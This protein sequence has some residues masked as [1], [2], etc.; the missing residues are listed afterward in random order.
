MNPFLQI[1]SV[2]NVVKEKLQNMEVTKQSMKKSTTIAEKQ[3]VLKQ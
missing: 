1:Q 3:K 2:I